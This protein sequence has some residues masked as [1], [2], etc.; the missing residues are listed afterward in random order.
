M[1]NIQIHPII[2]A[3]YAQEE[4]SIPFLIVTIIKVNCSKCTAA[5]VC[6]ECFDGSYVK[7]DSTGCVATCVGGGAIN[8]AKTKCVANCVANDNGNLLSSDSTRC[9][10]R[11]YINLYICIQTVGMMNRSI[12]M[13]V[14]LNVPQPV[15]PLNTFHLKAFARVV[16]LLAVRIL[17]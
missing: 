14:R 8:Y 4:W 9:Y 6:T 13:Q 16:K 5:A 2:N 3:S 12:E 17:K 11:S 7:T 1:D 10:A 15:E